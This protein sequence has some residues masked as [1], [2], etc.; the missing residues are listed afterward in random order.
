MRMFLALSPSQHIYLCISWGFL[1]IP[2]LNGGGGSYCIPWPHSLS[3]SGVPRSIG[4][5]ECVA[6]VLCQFSLFSVLYRHDSNTPCVVVVGPLAGLHR[7]GGGRCLVVF[8]SSSCRS[9]QIRR[10]VPIPLCLCVCG[11]GVDVLSQCS[12]CRCVHHDDDDRVDYWSGL[13]VCLFVY[14]V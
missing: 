5:S 11:L 8:A 4:F 3:L 12:L 10:T 1:C 9:V 13:M 6:L 14:V 2:L 7:V